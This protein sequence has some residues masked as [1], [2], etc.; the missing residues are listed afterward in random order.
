[1]NEHHPQNRKREDL[2]DALLQSAWEQSDAAAHQQRI[3]SVMNRIGLADVSTA[4]RDHSTSRYKSRRWKPW[5]S[6]AVA[7]SVLIAMVLGVQALVPRVAMA[8]VERSIAAAKEFV[9]RQYRVDVTL[10]SPG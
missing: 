9:A 5:M 6:W 7:A 1:M 3:D 2:I 10:R 4:A 8:A